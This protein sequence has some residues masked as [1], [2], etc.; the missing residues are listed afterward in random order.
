MPVAHAECKQEQGDT[1]VSMLQSFAFPLADVACVLFF[2]FF[3]FF[4][5]FSLALFYF[6]CTRLHMV[7]DCSDS[8]PTLP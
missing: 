8:V 5:L 6:S 1:Q 4:V 2:F 3:F 7:T